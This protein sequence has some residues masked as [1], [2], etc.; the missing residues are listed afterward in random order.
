MIDSDEPS[1]T[2]EQTEEP[3]IK[4]E[5]M[6]VITNQGSKVPNA[7]TA[8]PLSKDKVSEGAKAATANISEVDV[9]EKAGVSAAVPSNGSKPDAQPLTQSDEQ[10]MENGETKVK[11]PA[12]DGEKAKQTGKKKLNLNTFDNTYVIHGK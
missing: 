3:L 1:A 4:V 2:K 11:S 8:N 10:G 5:K 12:D 7:A 9:L 6:V